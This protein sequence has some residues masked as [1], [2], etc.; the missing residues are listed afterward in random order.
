LPIGAV[1]AES[2]EIFKD[3]QR[4][5]PHAL[6]VIIG[7][8]VT[9]KSIQ[10][11]QVF[12]GSSTEKLDV[13]YAAQ[14]NL[15]HSAEVTVWTQGIFEL[16]DTTIEALVSAL[17]RF[18]FAVFVFASDD[19]LRM[20]KTTTRTVRDNVLF[21]L[22]LFV[23][24][25]GKN[26]CFLLVPRGAEGLQL[27]SDLLGITPG[28]YDSKRQDGNL[29]AALGPACSKLRRTIE[30]SGPIV[31]LR[32]ARVPN[33][34]V[35]A[36]LSSELKGDLQ[37][38]LAAQQSYIEN[39][40]RRFEGYLASYVQTEESVDRSNDPVQRIVETANEKLSPAAWSL[41]VAISHRHLTSAQFKKMSAFEG[42]KQAIDELRQNG[43][44]VP[45]RSAHGQVV[46]W[47]P[48]D[49]AR[50]ILKAARIIPQ[51]TEAKLKVEGK[52]ED[53]GY[54][55]AASKRPS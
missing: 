21:E 10:R 11:P 49:M 47:Y 53:A 19:I 16:S 45:V 50:H 20:R 3:D 34:R 4:Y 6:I 43:L 2:R 46:Y 26:R 30:K 7:S 22:G 52:L 17:A 39:T 33:K 40:M 25:L 15:E 32:T 27:P 35:T 37:Q 12:I 9:K 55:T 54:R 44:L 29:L 14:E 38:A 13:A 1:A 5:R 18:D 28:T 36:G 24:R 8:E 48:P 23:G 41:L 31:R 42:T 51:D